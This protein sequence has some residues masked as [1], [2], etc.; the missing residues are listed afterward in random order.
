MELLK[1]LLYL[2]GAGTVVFVVVRLAYWYWQGWKLKESGYMPPASP[3]IA[4]A[5]YKGVGHLFTRVFVGPMD[6]IGKE[7]EIFV[8]RGMVLPNHVVW[9]D[10]AV[11]AKA[12]SFSYRQIAKYAE[13]KMFIVRTI[14]A[15]IGTV[16]V[17]VEGGKT[18]DGA[19]KL[20]VETGSKILLQSFGSRLLVFSQ[21]KLCYRG[22]VKAEDF[23]TG[24]AR[25][26]LLAKSQC[27][28]EPIFALPVAIHYIRD[29]AL[30]TPLQRFVYACGLKYLRTRKWDEVIRGADGKVEKV[31]KHKFV[32][33][34]VVVAIGEPI[35]VTDM[36]DDARG[37]IEM[38]RKSIED[39]LALAVAFSERNRKR[40]VVPE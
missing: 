33:Y 11:I 31:I 30:A 9:T 18:Q 4:R 13:I 24:S 35:S 22:D 1:N 17:Q 37:A 29:A 2:I 8:G 12:I 38:V 32:V 23:R 5:T 40:A 39:N 10:F 20:I 34:G 36:P 6:I 21:G 16:G 14:A 26:L 27:E 15:W 3:K 25:M 19:G 7:N 28:G